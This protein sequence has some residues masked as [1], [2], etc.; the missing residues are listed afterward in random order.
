MSRSAI[1][2][3]FLQPKPTY[4]ISVA[5]RLFG[6]P[7]KELQGWIDSGE[8]EAIDTAR[9]LVLPWEEVVF[10]GMDF[11]SQAIV[12]EALGAD[13]GAA[14]PELVRLTELNVRLPRIEVT[15]LERVAGREER[16]IDAVLASELLDFVSAE[17]AWLSR[18]IPGLA[19]ALSWPAPAQTVSRG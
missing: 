17:T 8:I 18:E 16:T 14:I 1:R 3:L 9:G 11:W 4:T 5:A 6:M 13:V 19:D 2:R 15:A 7:A 10:F 12:E